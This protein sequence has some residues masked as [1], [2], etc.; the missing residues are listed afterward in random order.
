MKH[1]VQK[2]ED[3]RLELLKLRSML[4]SEENP[5][6]EELEEINKARKEIRKGESSS[7][8][9]LLEEFGE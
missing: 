3:V 2:L 6:A 4:V 8:N 1:L 9:A 7:L 5:T